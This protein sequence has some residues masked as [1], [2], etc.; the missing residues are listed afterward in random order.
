M[1]RL[2]LPFIVA[3]GLVMIGS[4]GAFADEP[5]PTVSV[6][7]TAGKKVCKIADKKLDELSGIVATKTG[8]IVVNDSTQVVTHKRVFFLD[9]KCKIVNEVTYS[10]KG[11]L[12][13]EDLVLSPDSKTVWIADTGDNSY[14]KDDGTR[15]ERIALW[16]MPVDGSKEPQLHRLTYPPG[17]YHDS[18]ALL[19][20]G[21][22][23]PLIVTKEIGKAAG[24][25]QPS[26]PLQ[27]N[28]ET[29]VPLRRVGQ[30]TVSATTTSGNPYARIG[31]KTIDG[32]AVAPTGAKVVLRTYTDAL[33]WD[34]TNGDV[35]GAIQ[36]KPRITGL[37]NETLGEAIT[38]SADGKSFYTVSDM[39]GDTDA[40][41]YILQY[42]PATTVAVLSKAAAGADGGGRKWYSGLTPSNL[43]DLTYLV[44]GVGA[45]GLILVGIGLIGIVGH[46]KRMRN[47][48]QATAD[49]FAAS[50][51]AGDPETEL[52]G[53]GG[54][55]QRGVYGGAAAGAFG[56]AAAG[57]S[58]AGFY[59]GANGPVY[60]SQG[61]TGPARAGRGPAGTGGLGG[62]QA[63][64]GP[65]G[66]AP[67]GGA[68]AGGALAGSGP[69]VAG[70]PAGAARPAGTARPAGPANP[71]GTARPA[72][73]AGGRGGQYGRPG[74]QQ[75][76]GPGQQPPRAGQPPRGAQQPPRKGVYGGAAP[77]QDPRAPEGPPARAPKPTGSVQGSGAVQRPQPGG[78]AS[79]GPGQHPQGGQRQPGG[80]PRKT[81]VYGPPSGRPQSGDAHADYRRPER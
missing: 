32:G 75:P 44:G 81:G 26:G 43:G 74:G 28:N 72:G 17:D 50:P 62:P 12:D 9:T 47:N 31:N 48:P 16:S 30:I 40:A 41:N 56:G 8:F 19:L 27:V 59:G 60:G 37:P 63:G 68:L 58:P 61:G 34:V 14:N 65:N 22:G 69:N 46:R 76:P 35:L 53:V 15:R 29:G 1:R 20:S 25:Y 71:A 6:P 11:P 45:F 10:G 2:V 42:T 38:Y 80:A 57:G 67:M 23:T 21:D 51:P 77:G 73:P 52:I 33:E 24:I 70:A 55:P 54:A 66:G 18:E 5:A 4:S 78:G 49:D 7:A 39:S 3:S 13:T 79:D 64:G 36:K